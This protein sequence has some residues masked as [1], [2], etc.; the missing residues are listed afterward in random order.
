[1]AFT[2]MAIGVA[3]M[4]KNGTLQSSANL[5]NYRESLVSLI[6]FSNV[7]LI[8]KLNSYLVSFTRK[9]RRKIT[10]S[11][12]DKSLTENWFIKKKHRENNDRID[13]Y[14]MFLKFNTKLQ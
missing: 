11:E 4:S 10:G 12:F 8:K 9:Q 3:V 14:T 5:H 6:I 7:S 13:K 1:M 2:W